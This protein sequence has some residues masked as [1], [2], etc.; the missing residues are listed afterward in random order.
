MM[1]DFPPLNF[2]GEDYYASDRLDGISEK[3]FKPLTRPIRK[4]KIV[5][6]LGGG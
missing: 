5:V 2:H 1:E 6:R 3:G 4:S